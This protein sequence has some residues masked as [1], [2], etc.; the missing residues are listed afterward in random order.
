MQFGSLRQF[1][2][3][4]TNISRTAQ[5]VVHAAIKTQSQCLLF[6]ASHSTPEV[7]CL[8]NVDISQRKCFLSSLSQ[9]DKENGVAPVKQLVATTCQS[10]SWQSPHSR[11]SLTAFFFFSFSLLQSLFNIVSCLIQLC[12][13][14]FIFSRATLGKT[15]SLLL[16]KYKPRL[17][18][19]IGLKCR[20]RLLAFLPRWDWDLPI[21]F[22]YQRPE[23]PTNQNETLTKSMRFPGSQQNK[24]S[25]YQRQIWAALLYF[26]AGPCCQEGNHTTSVTR[27]GCPFL[28]TGDWDRMSCKCAGSRGVWEHSS[29]AILSKVREGL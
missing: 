25:L 18:G 11:C 21:C 17:G 2:K 27:R 14:S 20:M 15:A 12:P 23:E 5:E 9:N 26:S 16:F 3:I 10:M 13:S 29:S 1:W 28:C 22:C 8:S 7:S 4:A 24:A 19:P 6:L